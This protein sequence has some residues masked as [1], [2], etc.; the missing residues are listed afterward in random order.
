MGTD[1]P[2]VGKV[3]LVTGGTAG[4]GL[5]AARELARRGA[6]VIIVGRSEERCR[7][8]VERIR[9]DAASSFGSAEYVR[10]DLSTRAGVRRLAAEVLARRERLDVLINNV[11]ALFAL[12]SES[13]EGI[14]M[15]LAVN[16][17]APFLLTNLLLDAVRASGGGRIINVSSDA[18]EM[19]KG[20]D[21][22]DPQGRSGR[23]S[24]PGS[25]GRSELKSFIFAVS[26]P[27][28]HP[29]LLRYAQSKLANLLFTYELARRVEGT[30][31][32]VNALHP[33]FVASSFTAGNGSYGWFMRRAASIAAISPEAG[34]RTVVYL[35]ASPEVE[36]VTG[37]YFV[38]ERAV[39]SSAA[40][41]DEAAQRRL[42]EM[43]EEMT[44]ERSS[45]R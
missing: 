16:H 29:G 9:T 1:E 2:M 35:A 38:K 30:G 19:V 5:A 13:E 42:W 20:F 43:S 11:G 21:F 12:R 26:A 37:K 7:A 44:G 23:L 27:R 24:G 31:V 40:S 28:R 8:A 45:H 15:T 32:T 4:I 36:G 6:E 3:C 10:A 33:G 18:H 34:A 25:D 39:A 41:Y 17:L 14:E 22:E